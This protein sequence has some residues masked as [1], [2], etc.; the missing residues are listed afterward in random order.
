MADETTKRPTEQQ[1]V[2]TTQQPAH[3]KHHE[4][5]HEDKRT[6]DERK[7]LNEERE[8]RSKEQEEH[9]KSM[10]GRP[11]P[12]QEE[13]DLIKTGHHPQLEPDGST[14]PPWPPTGKPVEKVGGASYNTRQSTAKTG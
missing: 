14:E 11:T 8:K 4:K 2:A 13:A 12:T 5:Q 1:A 7:R 9:R 6:A 10:R 3:E